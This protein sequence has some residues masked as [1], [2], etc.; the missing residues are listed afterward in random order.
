[1]TEPKPS[2]EQIAAEFIDRWERAWNAQGATLTA[3]LYTDDSVLVG[4]AIAIGRPAI[5]S[6]LGRLFAAGW[7]RITI[8]LINAREV[9]G[10]VLAACEFTATGSGRPRVRS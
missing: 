10:V 3:Q 4:G 5:E 9:G 2:P 1:M 8:K 7:K 6:S